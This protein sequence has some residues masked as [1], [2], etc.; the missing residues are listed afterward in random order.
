MFFSTICLVLPPSSKFPPKFFYVFLISIRFPLQNFSF[1][2]PSLERQRVIYGMSKSPW[3]N[4]KR[5]HSSSSSLKCMATF[6][7]ISITVHVFEHGV[8]FS[9][10]IFSLLCNVTHIVSDFNPFCFPDLGFK[11]IS[12]SLEKNSIFFLS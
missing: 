6:T 9:C 7:C 11:T 4:L 2:F 3:G 8:T 10:K 5:I 1:F 12:N